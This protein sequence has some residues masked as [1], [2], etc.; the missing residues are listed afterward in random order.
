MAHSPKRFVWFLIAVFAVSASLGG[1]AACRFWAARKTPEA[2]TPE[3]PKK[4]YSP[5]TGLET[6][7]ESTK[8]RLVAVMVDNHPDARPESGLDQAGLVYEVLAEG[9]ITRYFAV[10]LDQAPAEIGP[11]RSA[12]DYF[13]DLVMELDAIYVHCGQ[14]PQAELEIPKFHIND[15]NLE[16]N[17]PTRFSWRA[18]DRKSPNNLYTSYERIMAAAAEKQYR[19][20]IE[21]APRELFKRDAALAPTGSPA[22]EMTI[23]YPAGYE[24]YVVSWK[25]DPATGLYSRFIKGQPLVDKPTQKQLTTPNVIIQY[26]KSEAIPKD[27]KLRINVYLVGEGRAQVFVKGVAI[28]AKWKKTAREAPTVFTDAQGNPLVLVP[29]S[30]WIEVIPPETKVEFK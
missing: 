19:T 23:P 10:F 25:Y 17:V 24:G 20:T 29:G 30:T 16:F 12:R 18:G 4:F 22:T 2:P 5:L 3:P 9:G 21:G 13:L 14:S 1:V 28:E 6:T 7:E 11:V 26:V 27:P 8:R 15:V